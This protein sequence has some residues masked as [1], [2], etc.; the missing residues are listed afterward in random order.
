M[1]ALARSPVRLARLSMPTS[2]MKRMAP[3]AS[4]SV[5][6]PRQAL[7]GV[8][9]YHSAGRG[10]VAPVRFLAGWTMLLDY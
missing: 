5:I 4:V 6:V 8:P 10:I 7:P 2:K 9:V 1:L 3:A